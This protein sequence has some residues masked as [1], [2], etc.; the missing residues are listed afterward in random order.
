MSMTRI[1]AGSGGM[2][3]FGAVIVTPVC[4]AASAYDSFEL[5]TG[6]TNLPHLLEY[7]E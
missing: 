4:L 7:E 2:E 3:L 1:V 5:V 6:C